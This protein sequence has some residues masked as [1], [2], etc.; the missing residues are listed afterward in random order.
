MKLEIKNLCFAYGVHQ[1]V[2]DVSFEAREGQFLAVLGV[3]GVG[4]STML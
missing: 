2:R 1:V 3:N 4:K